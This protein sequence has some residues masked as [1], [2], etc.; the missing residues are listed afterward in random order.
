MVTRA[1]L[2]VTRA[3]FIARRAGAAVRRAGFAV[4][5]VGWAARRAGFA[6]RRVGCAAKRAGFAVRRVGCAASRAGFAVRRVGAWEIA[7]G[8]ATRAFL[9][10]VRLLIRDFFWMAILVP[11]NL[12]LDFDLS[13]DAASIST[14]AAILLSPERAGAN[15]QNQ[16]LGRLRA[17]QSSA[18]KHDCLR[19]V[20]N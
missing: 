9:V 15:P 19:Q 12:S 4:R 10:A 3:G 2:I 16:G 18:G 20:K 13:T 1:G 5:R 11:L 14:S 17:R 7:W 6:V 8:F